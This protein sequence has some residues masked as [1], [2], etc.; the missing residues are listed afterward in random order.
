MI[1]VP[2][3]SVIRINISLFGL[4]MGIIEI[5]GQGQGGDAYDFMLLPSTFFYIDYL[6]IPISSR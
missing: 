2:K 3:P 1:K 5:E 4:E 6:Q